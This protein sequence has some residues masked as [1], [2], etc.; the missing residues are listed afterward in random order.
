MNFK[1]FFAVI[2]LASVPLFAQSYNKN[3]PVCTLFIENED[4]MKVNLQVEIAK[5]VREHTYGLM[6][7]DSMSTNAGMLFIFEN[8]TYRNFWMKN[9][10]IPLSIAYVDSSGT[11]KELYDMKPLDTSVTYPS[12]HPVRYAI[13]VNKGWFKQNKIRVGC[14]VL[15]NNCQ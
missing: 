4:N 3:L 9:T 11:I 6:N 13:E 8:D 14:K 10:K 12:K 15:F 7:R 1:Y 2:A 5:S